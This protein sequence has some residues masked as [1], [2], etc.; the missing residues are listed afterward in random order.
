MTISTDNPGG[1]SVFLH[2]FSSVYYFFYICIFIDGLNYPIMNR[3][4]YCFLLAALMFAFTSC[5]KPTPDTPQNPADNPENTEKPEQPQN[6]EDDPQKSPFLLKIYDLSSVSV[7]VEVEPLDQEAAY[8]TDVINEADFLQ[9]QKYG[10]DD[11]MTW[12]IGSMVEKTGKSKEVVIDMISS[13]GNDGFILTSLQPENAYYAIAVGIGSDGM[14]TTDVVYERFETPEAEVSENALALAVDDITPVSAVIKTEVTTEDPYILAVEP[15]NIISGMSDEELADHIIQSNIAW[16]GLEAITY[17]GDQSVGWEGKAGWNYVAVAFGYSNG[18]V[19]TEVVRKEFRMGESGDPSGCTFTFSQEFDDFQ[20]HLSVA[21]SDDTVVYVCNYVKTSDL[22]A[23]IASCGTLDAALQECY[24][25]LTEDLIADLG[26]R[27]NVI[28]LISAMQPQTFS[29]KY[30]PSTE[31]YQWAVP[32]DQEGNPTAA[33]SRSRPFTTPEEKISDASLK[34]T[35]CKYYD[36]TELAALYPQFNAA[37][38]FAV[39]DLVVKPSVLATQWWSY[40]ALE[41]LTDRSREV[42]I[43]NLL[44]APTEANLERQLIVSYW[45]VNT[46]MGVAQDENGVYGPLLLQVL[47]L[48]KEE[49][50]PA[51]EFVL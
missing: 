35:S 3:H 41:D 42:I 48:K 31:Y 36:G 30:E 23:L 5:E 16:G 38:G 24:N 33:F 28:D 4:F 11:Y 51:S 17:T 8:Y 37:K 39:V 47:D 12:F 25:L 49:A 45:G 27:E 32:V 29:V 19:T 2:L 6:P 26:T 10:F 7:T 9:A 14:T 13:Y 40:I 18:A 1:L 43:K 44:N 46:I 34:V 50:T 21:P 22:L 15:A 20:M